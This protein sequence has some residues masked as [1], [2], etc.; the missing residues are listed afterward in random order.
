MMRR[1]ILPISF[2]RKFTLEEIR[3][4]YH[5]MFMERAYLSDSVWTLRS[6]CQF[7]SDS[8]ALRNSKLALATAQLPPAAP[9]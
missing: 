1:S 7:I 8:K 9:N 4:Q 6:I 2:R 3:G 5:A